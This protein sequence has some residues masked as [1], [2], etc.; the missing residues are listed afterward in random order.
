MIPSKDFDGARFHQALIDS[1]RIDQLNDIDTLLSVASQSGCW[2]AGF[3]RSA[4]EKAQKDL[5][6]RVMRTGYRDENGAKHECFRVEELDPRTGLLREGYK[7]LSFFSISNFE[8]TLRDTS[9]RVRREQ[10][11]I[12]R[13]CNLCRQMHGKKAL[14]EIQLRLGLDSKAPSPN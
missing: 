3:F 11:K 6:R 14:R 1:G 13:L 2:T 9:A 12:N 5:L 4:V 7:Q 8:W 10:G